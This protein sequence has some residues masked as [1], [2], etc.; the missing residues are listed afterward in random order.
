MT[1]SKT[2]RYAIYSPSICYI[3]LT[4]LPS[5]NTFCFRVLGIGEWKTHQF[6]FISILN[7]I[8]RIENT[9][10]LLNDVRLS[11]APNGTVF[12]ATGLSVLLIH[13]ILSRCQR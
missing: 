10:R 8:D 9:I 1:K 13:V 4:L 2:K 3:F 6:D 12:L 7:L 5:L 11:L